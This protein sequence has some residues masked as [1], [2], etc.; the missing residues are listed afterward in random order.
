MTDK[1]VG[2]GVDFLRAYKK[3]KI[4]LESIEAHYCFDSYQEL[5]HFIYRQ[6]DAAV[7]K[8]IKS[9]GS[10]GKKPTLFKAYWI[11]PA[12]VDES[13]YREELQFQIYPGLKV[14]YYLSHLAQYRSDREAVLMLSDFL[15]NQRDLL[16]DEVSLNERSFQIWGR[17]KFLSE[18]GRRILKNLDFDI[19]RLNY[20][21][22]AEPIAYFTANKCCPQNILIIENKDTFYSMRKFMLSGATSLLGLEVGTLVYGGG[23]KVSKAF[24]YF[25]YS[26]EPYLLE[27]ANQFYYFGDLDYEGIIIYESLSAHF[28]CKPFV[29]GYEKMLEKTNHSLLPLTKEGQNRNVSDD[30]FSY[31]D[32]Q[33]SKEMKGILEGNR[34]IP[35]EILNLGDF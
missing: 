32:E 12:V 4:T 5:C 3:K 22:T 34:Y 27:E 10:N 20:Y 11:L 23:K 21:E 29:R 7:L 16:K 9:S 14:D 24:Q 15:L 2:D 25:E 8:P 33:T 1:E 6:I 13:I 18:G 30:F 26:V 17:E 19:S 31:F 35:Q 28:E